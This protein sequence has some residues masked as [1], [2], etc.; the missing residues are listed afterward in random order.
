[1]SRLRVIVIGDR[2]SPEFTEP[3][4]WLAQQTTVSF[5]A[6]LQA[7]A[8]MVMA[9]Q[10]P[11]DILVVAQVRPGE[12][13][14]ADFDSLRAAAPLAPIVC[15]LG[16]H[17][18]GEGRTGKPWPGAVRFYAHQFIARLGRQLERLASYGATAWTPP[19]TATEDDRLLATVPAHAPDLSAR[20]DIVSDSRAMAVALGDLLQSAGCE[21]AK[22][23]ENGAG[24]GVDIV[25]FDCA[26]EFAAS[27]SSFTR[28]VEQAPQAAK[29]A[30]VGFPRVEDQAMALA[31][32]A[33]VVVSKPFH[34]EDLL[35]QMQQCLSR[36]APQKVAP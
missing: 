15:L 9:E 35:W 23:D 22:L 18:Q 27:K 17:C 16:S 34:G 25:L 8:A 20:V 28:L 31:C 21:V 3:L 2:E 11:A 30:L 24:E 32:G 29:I 13:S 6:E 10:D 14:T 7:A 36:Q 26:G 4:H 19:F 1:M 33:S 12:H 5:A